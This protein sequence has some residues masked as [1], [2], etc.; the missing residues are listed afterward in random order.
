VSDRYRQIQRLG[1]EHAVSV[2]CQLLTVS[3]SGYY[4]WRRPTPSPRQ[5]EDARL[6][7]E[8][9][10][11]FRCAHCA[12]GRPRLTRVLRAQGHL[13]GERRI[14]RLMRE[15][16]LCA[17]TRRRFRPRTTD[18]RH[19]G[20]IAPNRLPERA[21]KLTAP[22]QIWGVDMTYLETTAGWL[23]LAIVLDLYSRRVVGW[24]FDS[25]MPAALPKAA[26]EMALHH[27]RPPR[28]LLHHSDRGSQYASA[29]YRALLRT[30][31]LEASMSRTANP[32]DNAA[33]ESFF[34]TLKTECC[35]QHPLASP[36]VTKAF[37]FDYIETFYNRTRLHSA[38][39]F[40]SPADFESNS[41]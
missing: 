22:D 23:Y 27:R 41:S 5:Q 18:S 2:L 21:P 34:S 6:R 16:G 40:Q 32:Y 4:T 29:A 24:A 10:Q 38:L 11:A 14:G 33:V 31:G 36:A 30:H 7:Q 3:R 35:R 9:Q 37:I 15:A 19:E 12:Y 28:G 39:G 20:P 8:L 13:C 17:R 26:L 1:E 25:Q